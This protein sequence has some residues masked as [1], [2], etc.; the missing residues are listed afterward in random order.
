MKAKISSEEKKKEK[1]GDGISFILFL[2]LLFCQLKCYKDNKKECI[3][4]K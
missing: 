3:S 4:G 1:P 2:V